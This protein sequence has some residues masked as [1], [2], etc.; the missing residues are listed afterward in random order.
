MTQRAVIGCALSLAVVGSMTTHVRANPLPNITNPN[1]QPQPAS[2]APSALTHDGNLLTGASGTFTP[3]TPSTI[4]P[5]GSDPGSAPSAGVPPP[6]PAGDCPPSFGYLKPPTSPQFYTIFPYFTR[7]SDGG[8]DG[9]DPWYGY[10]VKDAIQPGGDPNLTNNGDPATAANMAGHSIAVE[11]EIAPA[12]QWSTTALQ[13]SQQR[14]GL[15]GPSSPGIC[16]NGT[17]N[18]GYG[19]T[20]LYGPAPASKPPIGVLNAPPF[21]L[22]PTLLASV[23]GTWRIGTV[24]TLPGPGT[25]RTYVHIPTCAWLDSSV[26]TEPTALHSVTSTTVANGYTV[27]LVYNVTVTPGPVTWNWGDGTQTAS[28]DAPETGPPTLPAYDAEAQAWSDPCSVSHDYA[29]VSDGRTI[30]AT[31]SF[32]IAITVF[33]NDG[34]ATHSQTVPCNAATVV[35]TLN[36]G[37]GQ[38]WQSGPHPVDQIEPIPFSPHIGG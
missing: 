4:Q 10:D 33:W 22:G 8:Y 24:G 27:F 25:T 29:T 15:L 18:Y 7:S 26:P 31:Q 28:V 9:H 34:L 35:C 32:T 3:I 21:G 37:A 19:Q 17:I 5:G 16:D 36:I 11:I 1:S 30:T 20:Y 6:Y 38:G 13:W 23:A 14:Q 2:N 12:G